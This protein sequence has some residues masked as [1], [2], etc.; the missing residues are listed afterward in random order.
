MI[1]QKNMKSEIKS[2][3]NNNLKVFMGDQ[4]KEFLRSKRNSNKLSK[5]MIMMIMR[6]RRRRKRRNYFVV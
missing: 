5:V 3:E 4:Y 2:K 1:I 6:R